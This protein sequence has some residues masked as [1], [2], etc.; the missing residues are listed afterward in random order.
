MSH[1]CAELDT[2]SIVLAVLYK[3]RKTTRRK[4]QLAVYLLMRRLG[5]NCIDYTEFQ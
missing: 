1:R 3:L 5:Y 4:L 2:H